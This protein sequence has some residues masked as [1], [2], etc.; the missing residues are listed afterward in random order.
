MCLRETSFIDL[1][2]P[3]APARPGAAPQATPI[4][5]S[6]RLTPMTKLWKDT[7]LCLILTGAFLAMVTPRTAVAGAVTFGREKLK[8][9]SGTQGDSSKPMN[10]TTEAQ[11]LTSQAYAKMMDAQGAGEWDKAGHAANA[12]G[13]LQ[14][15][16][17]EM[18]LAIQAANKR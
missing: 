8:S 10:N 5:S 12:A 15:A 6:G 13:L 11:S 17:N 4:R 1:E 7:L 16:Q 14:K 18:N 9:Q 2:I 3:P